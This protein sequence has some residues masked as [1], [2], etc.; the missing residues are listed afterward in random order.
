M[1]CIGAGSW[2]RS[3]FSASH[4]RQEFLVHARAVS[5]WLTSL[6]LG[7]RG[8]VLLTLTQDGPVLFTRAARAVE[9]VDE[10]HSSSVP[11]V[12]VLFLL[13]IAFLIGMLCGC[14]CMHVLGSRSKKQI[15]D[16]KLVEH[17]EVAPIVVFTSPKGDSYH[18][19]SDCVQL[20]QCTSIK[21]RPVCKTCHQG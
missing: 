6:Q 19:K 20:R 12:V 10:E 2:R 1:K 9:D 17:V 4:W 16:R 5:S 3:T 13:I 11:G 15:V 21:P 8:I 7:I 14:G 18:M